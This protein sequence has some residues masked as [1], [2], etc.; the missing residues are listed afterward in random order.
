LSLPQ[1]DVDRSRLCWWK[2]GGRCSIATDAGLLSLT[3]T[4]NNFI[5]GF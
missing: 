4:G 5:A 1:F 2:A 3:R